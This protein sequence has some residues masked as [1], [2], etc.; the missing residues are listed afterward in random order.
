VYLIEER[1]AAGGVQPTPSKGHDS[2]V[3][4]LIGCF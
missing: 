1:E 2:I 4:C 3:T